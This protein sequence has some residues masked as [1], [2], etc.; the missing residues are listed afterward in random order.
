MTTP[1]EDPTVAFAVAPDVQ[2]PPVVTSASNEVVPG[3]TV[4]V[5]VI[6]AGRAFTVIDFVL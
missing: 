3:Q 6:E 1:E 5:P 4:L 2:A